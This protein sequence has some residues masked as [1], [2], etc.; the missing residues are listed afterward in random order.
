M[1]DF[2]ISPN[3]N[4]VIPTVSVDPGPNWAENLNSSLALV[5]QHDHSSGN[6][7]P[8]TP[9]GLNISSDLSFKTTN[10]AIDLL[11]TVYTPQSAVLGPLLTRRL[12]VVGD[13]LYYND[14]LGNQIRI[15]QS[16]GVAGSPGS[17]ANL[18][19]PAS[20][21]YVSGSSTFVWQSDANTPANMDA[22]SFVLRNLTAN[23]KGLTLSPPNAMAADYTI[24]LPALPGSGTKF[25]SLDSSGNMGASIAADN[26]TLEVSSNTLQV[27]A[28]GIG[29]NQLANTG[30]TYG[31]LQASSFTQSSACSVYNM[32]T[33]FADV[34]NLSISFTSTGRPLWVGLIPSGG[35]GLS[36]IQT[37]N[38]AYGVI[39]FIQ[40]G[41]AAADLQTAQQG[42][43]PLGGFFIIASGLVPGVNTFKVQAFVTATGAFP[44]YISNAILAAYE[45][46]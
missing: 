12:Y 1:A 29:T 6:G 5:D 13:D 40:N 35:V 11:S 22:A 30:V 46:L 10:S 37:N 25:V 36:V 42:N 45:I 7:V 34:T 19:S 43:S 24:V 9:A 8:V 16:G 33:S 4:L 3:M 18:T 15:T 26:T 27:K 38:N 14:G 2:T 41:V 21:T 39:R 17:I 31:K 32:T 20:A 28:G 44:S 23:S